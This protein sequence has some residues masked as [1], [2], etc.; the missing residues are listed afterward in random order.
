ME[1]REA[2]PRGFKR[3]ILDNGHEEKD[4][5]ASACEP[6]VDS[7]FKKV[8]NCG[9]A[10]DEERIEACVQGVLGAGRLVRFDVYD[11]SNNPQGSAAVEVLESVPCSDGFG[12]FTVKHLAASDAGYHH[13]AK[14]AL[15][16]PTKSVFHLCGCN[17]WECGWNKRNRKVTHISKWRLSSLSELAVEPWASATAFAALREKVRL[18]PKIHLRKVGK[19]PLAPKGA[20]TQEEPPIDVENEESAE[21]QGQKIREAL[22]T[23]K[24]G[25][26]DAAGLGGVD[27]LPSPRDDAAV[28]EPRGGGIHEHKRHETHQSPTVPK[29]RRVDKALVEATGKD[30]DHHDPGSFLHDIS[31][32]P[33]RIAGRADAE[34]LAESSKRDPGTL[35]K[36]GLEEM[37][38]YLL[39]KPGGGAAV[40]DTAEGLRNAREI[41]TLST[42][43][44]LLLSGQFARLGD[45]LMQRLKAVES[46]LTDGWGVAK[47]YEL[48]PPSKPAITADKERDFAAKAALRAAKLK[49][50]LQ[51]AHKGEARPPEEATVLEVEVW[52]R[53]L[54]LQRTLIV[55]EIAAQKSMQ[56]DQKAKADEAFTK[57][58]MASMVTSEIG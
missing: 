3:T 44:D 48:I 10:Q 38:R 56:K 57:R 39:D 47:H 27:G 4:W 54:P 41:V 55:E 31:S 20:G 53:K 29:R 1:A 25:L 23:G 11:H 24:P 26:L 17:A 19:Q 50:S 43:L 13:W 42:S 9:R 51:K 14:S 46:S 36:S 2:V 49:E 58:G 8:M 6:D 34:P 15:A 37:R 30:G 52:K 22:R 12:A 45:V 7:C 18:A 40:S 5:N 16:D 35:L 33:L 28:G 21:R 32:S